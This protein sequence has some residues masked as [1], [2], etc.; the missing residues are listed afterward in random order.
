MLLDDNLQNKDIIENIIDKTNYDIIIFDYHMDL[1]RTI[2]DLKNQL[3]NVDKVLGN[4]GPICENKHSLFITSLFGIK[5]Q[6]PVADYN[7]EMVTIDYE[8]QIPIFFY[9]YT[10]PRSKYGLRPGET[11]HILSSAVKIVADDPNLETLITQKGL[12][13]ILKMFK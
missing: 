2:V 4:I 12:G 10:F 8:D 6:L 11:H 13:G 5:K 7:A 9:D 1:S 3:E